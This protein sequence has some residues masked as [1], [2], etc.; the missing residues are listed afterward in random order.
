MSGVKVLSSILL[1]SVDRSWTVI[2]KLDSE[3]GK[4]RSLSRHSSSRDNVFVNFH[5]F[6][7]HI[8]FIYDEKHQQSTTSSSSSEERIELY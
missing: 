2:D 8:L 6:R 5:Q 4:I 1:E 3:Y 7:K